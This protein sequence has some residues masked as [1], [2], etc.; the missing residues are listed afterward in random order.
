MRNALKI[1]RLQYEIKTTTT[2]WYEHAKRM[3]K[4]RLSRQAQYM[5]IEEKIQRYRWQDQ[6]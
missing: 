5:K 1:G 4:E 2:T 6:I 3:G